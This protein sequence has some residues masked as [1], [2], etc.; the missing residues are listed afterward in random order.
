MTDLPTNESQLKSFLLLGFLKGIEFKSHCRDPSAKCLSWELL[1]ISKR[2]DYCAMCQHA[3]SEL[4]HH[5][6]RCN[7]SHGAIVKGSRWR[8][9]PCLPQTIAKIREFTWT[10]S[11][12]CLWEVCREHCNSGRI[13]RQM[14]ESRAK[15]KVLEE[16]SRAGSI[17]RGNGQTMFRVWTFL[18]T[19]SKGREREVGWD[20]VFNSTYMALNCF[21]DFG[22]RKAFIKHLLSNVIFVNNYRVAKSLQGT[23]GWSHKWWLLII[24]FLSA[25]QLLTV[26]FPSWN[27]CSVCISLPFTYTFIIHSA[28]SHCLQQEWAPPS[29]ESVK[30][31]SLVWVTTWEPLLPE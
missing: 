31:M 23:I 26:A 17:C 6:R 21:G 30:I 11:Y 1:Y 28:S 20:K 3:N 19:G 9:G 12:C 15:R 22:I 7:R 5:L 10:V 13:E 4:W 18:Q 2:Y 16:L 24:L 25:E 8:S 27:S 14:L 29:L